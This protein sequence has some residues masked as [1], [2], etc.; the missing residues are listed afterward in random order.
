MTASVSDIAAMSVIETLRS[1]TDVCAVHGNADPPAVRAEL[2]TN[3][4]LTACGKRI[5]IYHGRDAHAGLADR[6]QRLLEAEHGGTFDVIVFGHT[7]QP[8][9]D[10]NGSTLRFNPGSPAGRRFTEPRTF[11]ILTLGDRLESEIVRM[12]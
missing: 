2:P 1:L 5:G 11:G 3:R 6:A 9:E 8:T 4:V 7:H 10:W 12:S